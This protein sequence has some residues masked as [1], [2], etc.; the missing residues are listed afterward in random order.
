MSFFKL[1]AGSH[2]V[3]E[4][5]NTKFYAANDPLNNIVDSQQELAQMYPEQF[6]KLDQPPGQMQM[7]RGI[8]GIEPPPGPGS[9]HEAALQA[10]SLQ[11]LTERE[12]E[13]RAEQLE[14]MAKQLRQRVQGS[15]QT[16]QQGQGQGREWQQSAEEHGQQPIPQTDTEVYPGRSTPGV[17]LVGSGQTQV[18]PQ[19]QRE[20][21]VEQAKQ[22]QEVERGQQAQQRADQI[23]QERQQGQQGRP[24]EGAK[25]WFSQ[26]PAEKQ[27]EEDSKL[28]RMTVQQLK[29]TAEEEEIEVPANASK[30]LLIQAIRQGRKG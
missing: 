27:R 17:P 24:G 1:K 7:A 29:E 10:M 8:Y 9:P 20:R 16:A 11:P 3:G 15:R 18:P 30:A 6:E 14:Q 23:Q 26:L 19:Q 4:G 25:S 21:D 2:V 5:A 28:E 13:Q 22:Q 12:M